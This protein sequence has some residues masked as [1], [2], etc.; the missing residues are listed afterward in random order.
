MFENLSN[1]QLRQLGIVV[2]LA[3]LP[4]IIWSVIIFKGR[5]TS[6]W[7]LFL[8]FFLGTLT[9]TP[10]MFL[11]YIWAI[12]PQFDIY[13]V[14]N[15]NFSQVH[16]VAILTLLVV[17]IVEEVAKSGVVRIIDKTKI[18]IHTV[19]DALKY[20]ILAGLGFAFTENIFYFYYIW[21]SSGFVGLLFPLVF[22]SIFT[23]AAHMIFSGIYGYY[24]G[25]A[26]FANPI[27][28]QKLWLGEKAPFVS[29]MSKILGLNEGETYK[30]LTMFK[31]LLIV[32]VG[33]A[34][35]DFFLEFSILAPVIGIVFAGLAYL[36][37]LMAHKAGAIAFSGME[38]ASS[39]QKKDEDVVIELLG[40]WTNEGRYQD[41][42]DICQRLLMRDP[43]N[44]VVQLFQAKAMDSTKLSKLED[45]FGSIF[46]SDDDKKNDKTLRNLV[47]QKILM[48]ML[49]EKK[50]SLAGAQTPTQQSGPSSQPSSPVKTAPA[51]SLPK[52]EF[53]PPEA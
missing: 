13:S 39:M 25:I 38:R 14:I 50:P 3:A 20:S 46:K 22:R 16:T 18:G 37:Y 40:M 32:M 43:D 15:K 35:Y 31:G 26:K 19:G 53:S 36:L 5:R 27:L 29:F 4:A 30:E 8:A 47:R 52:P 51:P 48:D 17:G 42:I 44:K 41:V 9:V 23:V 33:H 45:S 7:T 2:F 6:F 12:Y 10:I 11:D 1:D 28:Q 24:F 21:Q 49:N 34:A